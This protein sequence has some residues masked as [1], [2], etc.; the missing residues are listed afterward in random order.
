MTGARASGD[1]DA[2]ALRVFLESLDVACALTPGGREFTAGMLRETIERLGALIALFQSRAP[3]H[4]G[5]HVLDRRPCRI[6]PSRYRRHIPG[7]L[8]HAGLRPGPSAPG[9]AVARRRPASGP[10][11]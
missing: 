7:V 2:I 11:R 1:E 4:R 8:G 9:A 10:R 5:G 6:A 3:N